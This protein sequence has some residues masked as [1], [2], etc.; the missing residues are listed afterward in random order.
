MMPDTGTDWNYQGDA[1]EAAGF[2]GITT[3][4]HTVAISTQVFVG[5]V[6]LMG[7]LENTPEDADKNDGWF[8][9]KPKS[10]N[11]SQS[12]VQLVS[13]GVTTEYTLNA[14]GNTNNVFLT[15]D[16]VTQVPNK[17][18][19]YSG[20]ILSLVE[21]P[22]DGVVMAV[23]IMAPNYK[24]EDFGEI[25]HVEFE[26]D[27]VTTEFMLSDTVIPGSTTNLFVNIN[28]VVQT[29]FTD[30]TYSNGVV[31]FFEAPSITEEGLPNVFITV[32]PPSGISSNEDYWVQFP[33]NAT[34]PDQGNVIISPIYGP[35]T[36]TTVMGI[37]EGNYTYIKAI[38]DRDYLEPYDPNMP[39]YKLDAVGSI[40][41]I[42]V[43]F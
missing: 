11:I 9:I 28:G 16:G 19:T 26:G 4:S 29:P 21:S 32:Y 18:F 27:G 24:P 5:R 17:D 35:R 8:V 40:S 13:D 41:R 14:P 34:D 22:A 38:L 23:R 12:V 30:F 42:L 31:S 25:F 20:N 1:V 43:N 6:Y 2:Y 15:F 39:Q 36:T 33:V 37:F 10:N 7:T 3:G